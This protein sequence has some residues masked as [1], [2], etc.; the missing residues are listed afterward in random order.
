MAAG[1]R[2][3][4]RDVIKRNRDGRFVD[5]PKEFPGKAALVRA[6]N[7][8]PRWRLVYLEIADDGEND[9]AGGEAVL[10]KKYFVVRGV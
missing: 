10:H 5:L 7:E 1:I 9:G 4:V 3:P 8:S 6:T 2:R